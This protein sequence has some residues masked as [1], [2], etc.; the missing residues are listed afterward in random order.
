MKHFTGDAADWLVADNAE[1]Q[2]AFCSTP[3]AVTSLV[4]MY[5]GCT[6]RS[7]LAAITRAVCS[8]VRHNSRAQ[9]MFVAAGATDYISTIMTL[10]VFLQSLT[11][12]VLAVG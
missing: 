8:V 2:D 6:R 11:S 1:F 4:A 9:K 3:D 7:L 5:D 12:S 10:K